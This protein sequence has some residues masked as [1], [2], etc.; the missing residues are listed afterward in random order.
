MSQDSGGDGINRTLGGLVSEI[1]SEQARILRDVASAQRCRDGSDP[2]MSKNVTHLIN[3]ALACN[4]QLEALCGTKPLTNQTEFDASG[5][6]AV[7]VVDD[8]ESI[9]VSANLILEKCGFEVLLAEDG[10]E[11]LALYEQWSESLCC[12]LLDFSMPYMRG[13][14][15]FARMC[16]INANIPIV[17]MSGL[18]QA[19][20]E[21]EFE[22]LDIAGLI[23]KPFDSPAL[24]KVVKACSSLRGLIDS[25]AVT[26]SKN[27]S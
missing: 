20:V 14:L 6:K 7:L 25:R 22:H 11:A 19:S 24:L 8:E 16:A 21:R 1:L 2:S 27:L 10:L 18:P 13:N 3:K 5:R 12:V 26:H 17:V 4:H 9:R 23:Q 15:V